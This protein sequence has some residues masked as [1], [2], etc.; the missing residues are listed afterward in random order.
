MINAKKQFGQNFIND[1]NLL[2]ELAG[3]VNLA[4][5]ARALEIG[6]GTGSLTRVLAKRAAWVTAVEID[7]DLEAYLR[8]FLSAYDNIDIIINDAMKL[9]WSEYNAD[10]FVSNLPYYITSNI[11]TQALH[12]IPAFRTIAVMVQKEVAD[13]IT[14]A[15]R[16][17]GYGPLSIW[18]QAIY[19]ITIAAVLPP[20]AFS[21]PP[22]VDSAFV[23]MRKKDEPIFMPQMYPQLDRVITS[24]F[25]S[26]RKTITNNLKRIGITKEMLDG[27][28]IPA[29]AR[30]EELDAAAYVK[31]I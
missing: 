12:S 22:S 11:L 19:D 17:D 27:A 25:A 15:P 20:S 16:T 1:E 3:F 18:A 2:E 23:V 9:D 6:A 29:M 31:L 30:A 13:K 21:P 8:V 26:R 5:D 4:P 14:A 28:G 24:A 7:R 10:C